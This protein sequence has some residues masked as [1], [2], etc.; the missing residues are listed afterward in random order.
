VPEAS[1][2]ELEAGPILAPVE[3][4]LD[5]FQ[6]P[7]GL[8]LSLIEKRKLPITAISL[9]QVADQYLSHVRALP[10]LNPDLLADFLVVAAKLLLIKSRAILPG[11]AE[12][13]D[14]DDP[15]H[16]LAVRLQEYRLFRAAAQY[17]Q[18]LEH[19][20]LRAY[21]HPPRPAV[22]SGPPPLAPIKPDDLA[23]ALT[24]MLEHRVRAAGRTAEVKRLAR[25]SVESRTALVL[26]LLQTLERVTW[27]QVAGST[28]DEAIATFLALLEMLR[29][30]Q[31]VVDQAELFGP[32]VIT[33]PLPSAAP[34]QS[35]RE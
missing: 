21:P 19:Q 30:D 12:P 32:I 24:N 17:L 10:E 31:V 29:R 2:T 7:I 27:E 33:R 14:E 16:E 15:A 1:R 5:S 13:Q 20:G 9:A 26:R 11:E 4:R 22:A 3:L 8:L 34:R 18:S 25:A 28:V 6:G 35:S 23:A